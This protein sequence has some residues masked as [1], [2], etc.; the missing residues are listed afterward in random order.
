MLIP[1]MTFFLI[2]AQ[3]L[4]ERGHHMRFLFLNENNRMLPL[5]L[6]GGLGGVHYF[7]PY[8]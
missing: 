3:S 6:K 4:L 5:F 1:G 8:V 7:A 2:T